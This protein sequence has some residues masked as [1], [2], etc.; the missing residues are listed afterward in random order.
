MILS[1]SQ[2]SG[3]CLEEGFLEAG[4]RVGPKRYD[5]VSNVELLH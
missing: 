5:V 4:G 1:F 3:V 2:G